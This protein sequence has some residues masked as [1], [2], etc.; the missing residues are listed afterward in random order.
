MSLKYIRGLLYERGQVLLDAKS[1]VRREWGG[2]GDHERVHRQLSVSSDSKLLDEDIRE[3]ARVIL[4][5]KK[6]PRPK[7]EVFLNKEHQR[8]TKRYSAF[9]DLGPRRH[10]QDSKESVLNETSL[11]ANHSLQRDSSRI[12]NYHG[13]KGV[14]CSVLHRRPY[15]RR[16]ISSGASSTIWFVAP[17]TTSVCV[18]KEGL[19]T[20]TSINISSLISFTITMLSLLDVKRKINK[21]VTFTGGHEDK[22]VGYVLFVL[23][24]DS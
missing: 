4:R 1:G 17:F 12:L 14:A 5:P 2:L 3:E 24:H 21:D 19:E 6:P 18:L 20:S 16:H 23:L 11:H 8:R 13:G 10:R 22:G 7:S 9:G 15:A